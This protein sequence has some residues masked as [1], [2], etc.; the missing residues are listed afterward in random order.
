MKYDFL[1]PVTSPEGVKSLIASWRW[2]SVM[3]KQMSHVPPPPQLP[4]EALLSKTL[5]ASSM[6]VPELLLPEGAA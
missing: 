3:M 5:N 2:C 1:H 4:A 6:A